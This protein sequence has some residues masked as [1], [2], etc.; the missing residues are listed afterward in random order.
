MY[1]LLVNE[2]SMKTKIVQRITRATIIMSKILLLMNMPSCALKVRCFSGFELGDLYVKINRTENKLKLLIF[3][4]TPALP[5]NGQ[6]YGGLPADL[7][8]M[9]FCQI[10]KDPLSSCAPEEFQQPYFCQHPCPKR[11]FQIQNIYTGLIRRST[12]SDLLSLVFFRSVSVLF[13]LCMLIQKN[14]KKS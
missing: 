10:L 12:S 8:M 2:N 6:H 3:T 7:G 4:T 14:I 1:K 11:K 9:P 5:F 13:I